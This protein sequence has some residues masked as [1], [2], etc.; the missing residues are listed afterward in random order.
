MKKIY[1]IIEIIVFVIL[2]LFF[3]NKISL[4]KSSYGFED[5]PGRST[6]LF[7]ELPDNTVDVLFLGDSHSFCGV[8]PQRL[9]DNEGI[10]SASLA[11][12]TQFISNT[13]WMLLDAVKDQD[14]RVIVL[15]LH[16]VEHS[17]RESVSESQFITGLI[18]MPDY[19]L[20]KLL[21]F[22]DTKKIDFGDCSQ[23]KLDSI[24][25]LLQFNSN[26]GRENSSL[27]KLI[28][29]AVNPGKYF[30]TFGYY[31]Q[32]NVIPLE[33]LS[34]G[35]ESDI[36]INE[37][38]VMDYLEKI[39]DICVKNDI[40]LVLM[41][42]PYYSTNA[43][44]AVYDDLFKWADDRGVK[45]IDLFDI[46]EEVGLDLNTDFRDYTHLNYNGAKKLSDYLSV[47]LKDNYDLTDHRGDSRYSLWQNNDYDYSVIEEEVDRNIEKSRKSN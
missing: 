25:P 31:P 4:I 16:S 14:I 18:A 15:E 17:Y 3:T 2:L 5:N 21:G 24:Y 32:T 10:S 23:I 28:D 46:Y 12:P 6:R 8:I 11:T 39:Y 38:F 27:K 22:Y 9:F 29:Y 45:T 43:Y 40:E 20:N 35:V 41:R 7:Y 37:T 1:R 19:S 47:Y 30:K 34:P 33:E 36:D 26:Y 44:E 13:Y 42:T